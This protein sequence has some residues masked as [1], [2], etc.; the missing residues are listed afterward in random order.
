[1]FDLNPSHSLIIL[2]GSTPYVLQP[3]T[4]SASAITRSS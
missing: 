1:M 2:S 4:A 3:H